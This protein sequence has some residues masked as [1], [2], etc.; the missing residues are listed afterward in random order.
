MAMLAT[1]IGVL[2]L[3][4]AGPQV[5]HTWTFDE[6]TAKADLV[7]IA[8]HISTQD[9][10]RRRSHPELKP[11]LRVAELQTDLKVLQ[12]LKA[13]ATADVR[14][15]TT[16]SLRHYSVIERS[17]ENVGSSLRFGEPGRA[18]LLFL[19]R[20]PDGMYEPVSGHTFPTDSVYFLDRSDRFPPPTP[21]SLPNMSGRWVLL[22]GA[23]APAEAAR[24]VQVTQSERAFA[25]AATGGVLPGSRTYALGLAGGI[26]YANG[27]RTTESANVRGES[28]VIEIVHFPVAPVSADE[29][30]WHSEVWSVAGD[31]LTIQVK[32]RRS[33]R[34]V[35]DATLVY[36]RR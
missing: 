14:V 3:G 27:D 25:V 33:D 16:L 20:Q 5:V 10:A 19:V 15:G 17:F 35:V 24:E 12:V 30:T 13:D 1:A 8:S 21:P 11:D 28:L 7:V 18:Y 32:E 2:C 6:L 29:S 34:T 36:R 31:R 22:N 23:D 4:F 9:T 26:Y